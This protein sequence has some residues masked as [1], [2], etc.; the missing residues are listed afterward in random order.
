MDE[1]NKKLLRELKK[2]L[3]DQPPKEVVEKAKALGAKL[4]KK[5]EEE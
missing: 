4:P 1:E 2:A 3:Q 5:D